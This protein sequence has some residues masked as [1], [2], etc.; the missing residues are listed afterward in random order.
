[1]ANKWLPTLALSI[2]WAYALIRALLDSSFVALIFIALGTVLI[3]YRKKSVVI[4]LIVLL[5]LP[6]LLATKVYIKEVKTIGFD[7]KKFGDILIPGTSICLTSAPTV[8]G[9]KVCEIMVIVLGAMYGFDL[10]S[11]YYL[12]MESGNVEH[13]G[14]IIRI[15]VNDTEIEVIGPRPL[16][17][18]GAKDVY[19]NCTSRFLWFC[20]GGE[21]VIVALNGTIIRYDFIDLPIQLVTRSD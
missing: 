7:P 4:L 13:G 15:V 18:A 11:N 16:W 17:I 14:N 20:T 21:W 9:P 12:L 19:F 8:I 10:S 3:L 6:S 5:L 2:A 1:M